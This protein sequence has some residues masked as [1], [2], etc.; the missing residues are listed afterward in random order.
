MSRCREGAAD[1][2]GEL[3]Q[4]LGEFPLGGIERGRH[5]DRVAFHTADVPRAGI[6]DQALLERTAT[7]RLAQ[8][9]L[10]R[11]GLLSR[12][13]LDELDPDRSEERRVGKEC[14]SRWSPYH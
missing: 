13:I 4:K 3:F 5:D 6:A 7:D 10:R 2:P 9:P 11:E 14:R 8:G 1:R 12:A